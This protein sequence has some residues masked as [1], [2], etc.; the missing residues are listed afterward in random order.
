MNNSLG[1]SPGSAGGDLKESR[2]LGKELQVEGG[3]CG[4]REELQ[5]IQSTENRLIVKRNSLKSRAQTEASRITSKGGGA[6]ESS[7]RR[8]Q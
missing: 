3:W 7:F 1:W 5:R 6:S 8:I 2:S 4:Q